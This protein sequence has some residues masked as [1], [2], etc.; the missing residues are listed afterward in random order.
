MDN[1]V[2][3]ITTEMDTQSGI[4]QLPNPRDPDYGDQ[5]V[6]CSLTGNNHD[7]SGTYKFV[8]KNG[9]NVSAIAN[10]LVQ[11]NIKLAT[12]VPGEYTI[13]FTINGATYLKVCNTNSLAYLKGCI[14]CL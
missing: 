11:G 8:Y 13:I 10:K 12:V 7:G 5:S 2:K 1:R 6:H 4:I 14:I 3:S 9:T